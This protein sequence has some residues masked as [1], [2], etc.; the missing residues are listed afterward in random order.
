MRQCGGVDIQN[1]GVYKNEK[2]QVTLELFDQKAK[3]IAFKRLSYGSNLS[4]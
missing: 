2:Y 4:K 3:F 1:Q